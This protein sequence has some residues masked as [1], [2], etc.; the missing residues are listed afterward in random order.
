M[1]TRP[2]GAAVVRVER[3]TEADGRNKDNKSFS[4]QCERA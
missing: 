1:Q 4:R 3:R 2:V